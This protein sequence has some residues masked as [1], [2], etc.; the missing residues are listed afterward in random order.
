[1]AKFRRGVTRWVLVGGSRH[2]VAALLLIGTFLSFVWLGDA[3]VIGVE[4]PAAVRGVAGGFI[5]GLIA[6]LSI[7]LG[8]NQLV[9]SQEFG[10][11]A[12][13]RRRI[14]GVR[15]YRHDVE[16]MAGAGPSPVLPTEFI[17]FV[18][19]TIEDEA[20]ALDG[21]VGPE[22][23]PEVRE[24]VRAYAR[25]VR[26]DAGR[27]LRSLD[28]ARPGRINALLSVLEYDDSYQLFEGRR[29]Q[30]AHGGRLPSETRR[31]LSDLI[32]T[33]ELFDVARTQFRTTYTQRALARLSRKLLYVGLPALVAVIILGL[34]RPSFLPQTGRARLVVV[35]ALLSVG[36]SPLAVLSAY[37]LRIATVSE[38]TV[39]AGPFVSRPSAG[40]N[41]NDRRPDDR[42]TDRI[43]PAADATEERDDR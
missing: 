9:L 1:M 17:T 29:L 35:S 14:D 25:M 24:A 33:L 43:D 7:V 21:S 2:G 38:R 3:G 40:R 16:E 32:E 18:A 20:A 42:A 41:G 27:A 8:I 13:I 31:T 4:D 39:A 5:P 28:R 37:L 36:L 30:R 19:R 22:A 11:A 6:F 12:E 26:D 34:A 23:D 15:K 10:S